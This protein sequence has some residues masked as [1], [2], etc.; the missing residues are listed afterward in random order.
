[1]QIEK[2]FVKMGYYFKSYKNILSRYG[3]DAAVLYGIIEQYA[4]LPKGKGY[5]YL[6]QTNMAEM[7][8]T[9]YKT[10]AR[11]LK[12]LVEVGLIEEVEPR[13][14]KKLDAGKYYKP[15]PFAEERLDEEAP[16]EMSTANLNRVHTNEE[17]RKV[18]KEALQSK[19]PTTQRE[20]EE[21][22]KNSST[23]SENEQSI[24]VQEVLVGGVWGGHIDSGIFPAR[25]P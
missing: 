24:E 18:L 16:R 21:W 1:L 20:T 19:E 14:R 22:L 23:R 8:G 25:V 17:R 13:K 5:C 10:V 11:T 7:M 6:S 3:A 2:G 12:K 4:R 15:V 9:S